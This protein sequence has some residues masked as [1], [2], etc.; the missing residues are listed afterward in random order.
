MSPCWWAAKIVREFEMDLADEPDWFAHL[1][2]SAWQG[3][4]ATVRVEKLAEDAK[5]LD[6]VTQADTIWNADQLYREPLR[7]QL[8][9][10]PRRGWNN[11]P[12]GM[13]FADG[14]Y[15]LYFQHNPVRLA[16]GQH[17]LGPRRQP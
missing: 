10:S 14:E 6:L 9:F 2:V 3:K 7:A 16:V 12:N 1:D 17:A 13:V 4:Q 11:D 8:H 5:T 15:H